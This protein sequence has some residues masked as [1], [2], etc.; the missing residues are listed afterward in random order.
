M[1]VKFNFTL[2]SIFA[3]FLKF[4]INV[5]WQNFQE[6]E[7][8][9]F[10]DKFSI[11]LFTFLFWYVFPGNANFLS[12]IQVSPQPRKFH[13]NRMI[14]LSKYVTFATNGKRNVPHFFN[15][16]EFLQLR[17]NYDETNAYGIIKSHR[18]LLCTPWLIGI[19]RVRR[20]PWCL[21]SRGSLLHLDHCV[22]SHCRV[23]C[24]YRL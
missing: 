20:Y 23:D 24:E 4:I 11:I 14:I 12:L 19:R 7:N 13:I 15:Y 22:V 2:P 6:R 1:Y 17:C 21:Q 16:N 8:E 9:I 10:R 3:I 18:M 5:S